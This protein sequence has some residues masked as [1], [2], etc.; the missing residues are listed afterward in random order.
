MKGDTKLL[1]LSRA[2]ANGRTNMSLRIRRLKAIFRAASVG[3]VSG[4]PD[5]QFTEHRTSSPV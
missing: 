3:C 1:A 4:I 2:T 5:A